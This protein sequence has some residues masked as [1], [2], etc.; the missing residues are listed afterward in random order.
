MPGQGLGSLTTKIY[1]Q[2]GQVGLFFC[3]GP[4]KNCDSKPECRPSQHLEKHIPALHSTHDNSTSTFFAGVQ[5]SSWCQMS[6]LHLRCYLGSMKFYDKASYFIPG[7]CKSTPATMYFHDTGSS[8]NSYLSCHHILIHHIL[9]HA[10][11]LITVTLSSTAA[12]ALPRVQGSSN[13]ATYTAA[14]TGAM[15]REGDTKES[16]C[17]SF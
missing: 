2:G 8:S 4:F 5:L 14:Y 9:I 16:R 11:A 17:S 1:Q 10:Q 3:N 13:T 15:V 7:P 6:H 12:P